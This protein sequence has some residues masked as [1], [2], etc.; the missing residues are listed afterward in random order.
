MKTRG[1]NKSVEEKKNKRKIEKTGECQ[2]VKHS[3]IGNKVA[4]DSSSFSKC[5]EGKQYHEKMQFA[6]SIIQDIYRS[7]TS[8]IEL[9]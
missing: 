2:N 9:S 8:K 6:H 1:G 7:R 4:I 5:E 3:T